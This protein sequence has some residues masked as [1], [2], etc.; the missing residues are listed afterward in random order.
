MALTPPASSTKAPA[1]PWWKS[2]WFRLLI[3]VG[4]LYWV[5]RQM[6]FDELAKLSKG[7]SWPLVIAALAIQITNRYLTTY[8]WR[9]LLRAKG[10]DYPFNQLLS[11][12][13]VSNFL[14]HFLPSAVGGDNVR[15]FTMARGNP[16]AHDA[17]S[18]VMME[19][20]T[21]VMS[22]A[23]LATLGGIWS[24]ARWGKQ[25]IVVALTLP[26]GVLVLAMALLWSG[27]GNALLTWLLGHFHRLP[28]YAFFTKVH[29]AIREFRSRPAA[30][31]TSLSVSTLIQ[32][33][34]VVSIFLLSRA[35]GLDLFIGEA[36]VLV[37]AVLFIA[38]LPLS[39]GGLGVQEGAFVV[40]FRLVGISTEAAFGLSLLARVNALISNMPG[41]LFLLFENRKQSHAAAQPPTRN[42]APLRIL[43]LMDKLG[44]GDR[45][46]GPGR[47]WFATLPAFNS[48]GVEVI[49]VV[50][51]ADPRLA[52]IFRQNSVPLRALGYSRVNPWTV[53]ALIRLIRQERIDVLH[54]HGDGAATFGRIAAWVTGTPAIV[55]YHDTSDRLP[56]YVGWLDR[57][58][59]PATARAV[60]I[61]ESVAEACVR[62]RH[63]AKSNI[64]IIPNAIEQGWSCETS[65][66][67]IASLRSLLGI[68]SQ[69][70]V[71]GAVSRFRWEKDV[72]TT[73][74]AVAHLVRSGADIHAVIVGEGEDRGLVEAAIKRNDLRDRVHLV[75]FKE[76]V[77]PYL[78]LMEVVI[79]SSVTEGFGLALLEAMA[80]GRPVV[81]TAVGGM[82]ELIRDG[83]NGLLAPASN[84]RALATAVGR[85]LFD[86]NLAGRVGEQAKRDALRYSVP[87]HVA[88]LVELYTTVAQATGHAGKGPG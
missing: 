32:M 55:H 82:R 66:Q 83:E 78:A 5:G 37:P 14:G 64:S 40:I 76:D 20:L 77:R 26:V 17:V 74:E 65:P 63:H 12:V 49:P 42:G 2:T 44:Y 3:A 67:A 18:T 36:L 70:R 10:M 88:A 54:L 79:F 80:M 6:E 39:I 31:A 60:A 73:I 47:L 48:G 57:L 69:G 22:L 13:W 8:K 23:L 27:P 58:L 59:S 68:P 30:V 61:S 46:H 19:R 81:A 16:R 24:Y 75:G 41:G 29:L 38:M 86:D 72:P 51:R 1:T 15:M 87:S 71:V 62:V 7:I 33:N 50:L 9:V 35:L 25:E 53:V 28:G 84:P 4:L 43:T 85:L 56:A 52:R 21:G 11:V 45:L 34:R